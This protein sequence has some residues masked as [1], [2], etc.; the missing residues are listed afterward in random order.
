M[1]K[2]PVKKSTLKPILTFYQIISYNFENMVGKV[3]SKK[4]D[5]I[6]GPWLLS[7]ETLLKFDS[8]M[9]NAFNTFNVLIEKDPSQKQNF[10]SSCDS[11][12]KLS[13]WFDDREEEQFNSFK[14]A[15]IS[16]S[17]S[18]SKPVKFK[19]VTEVWSNRVIIE[20]DSKGDNY[21]RYYINC[22][23][24][25]IKNNIN[26]DMQ[27]IYNAEKPKAFFS[28]ASIMGGT[29]FLFYFILFLPLFF[30]FDIKYNN[31][32]NEAIRN[33]IYQILSKESLQQ[34]DYFEIIKYMTIKE[35]KFYNLL[36]NDLL[37][38]SNLRNLSKL[39]DKIFTNYLIIGFLF[40]LIVVFTPKAS[41]AIGKSKRK[42]KFWKNYYNFL[43]KI[44]PVM[45]LLP[46]IINIISS[47]ITKYF[48]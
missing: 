20:L 8:L 24:D 26:Y 29:I 31:P 13:I 12:K 16:D 32:H 11:E 39:F 17:C 23:D 15:I 6:R 46:I 25:T 18:I 2:I 33:K 35:Y 5:G 41:F 7:E 21:F 10:L 34:E 37:D 44:F 42:V 3:K 1:P 4:E 45:I 38:T 14:E 47:F 27:Q 19:Y 36:E 28:Y 22:E 43:L 40:C 9:E 30:A 48:K